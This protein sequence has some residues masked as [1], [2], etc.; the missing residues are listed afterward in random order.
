MRFAFKTD[1][2]REELKEEA[3]LIQISLEM[4]EKIKKYDK[5]ID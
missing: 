3:K 5:R 1:E 4:I 2:H